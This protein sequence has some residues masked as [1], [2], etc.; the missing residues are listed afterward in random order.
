MSTRS[1]SPVTL[2]LFESSSGRNAVA[3]DREFADHGSRAH[4]S[5]HWSTTWHLS[6]GDDTPRRHALC[7]CAALRTES[8]ESL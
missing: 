4:C 5:H 7:T 2:S 3:V 8:F 6:A 1:S